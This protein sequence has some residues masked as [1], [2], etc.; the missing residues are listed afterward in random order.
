M[1]QLEVATAPW[2][3]PLTL[4]A[5]A[6]TLV[7]CVGSIESIAE[8]PGTE[9]RSAKAPSSAGV[10]DGTETGDRAEPGKKTVPGVS[11]EPGVAK[12]P[13]LCTTP[14]VST[15][16]MRR[17]THREFGNAVRDLLGTTSAERAFAPDT[18]PELFDTMASQGVSSLLADQYLDVASELAQ[19]ISN[20]STLVGC[21]PG[22]ADATCVRTFT[23]RFARRAYRRPLT[24][25]ERTRLTALYESTRS[26]ANADTAVRAF[27]AA[28]LASP[29]FL[30]RPEWGT[31]QAEFGDLRRAAPFELAARLSFLLWS[32]L[33]D[34]TLLDAAQAGTLSTPAQ[35]TAQAQRM[36]LDPRARSASFGF[37]EQWLGLDLLHS[38][39][40]DKAVYPSFS[41]GLRG[42]MLEET[43]RF[44]DHVIWE[45]DAKLASLLTAPYSFVNKSLAAL[46]KVQGPSDDTT[47]TQ[48]NLDANQRSGVLTQAS[49]L[50]AYAS[51]DT[52]SPV[53]R[54]KWVRTRMF[55]QDLPPPP[56]G[57]PVLAE[58]EEGISTRERF[59][60]HTSAPQCSSCHK[61]IDGLGFG[62]E[63][64][65]G[66]GAFRTIDQGVPVDA[67]GSIV[68]SDVNG[69]YEGGPELAQ[70]L[71]SS[72]QVRDCAVTQWFRFSQGR[73]E[74]DE[75]ACSLQALQASFSGNGGDLQ[76]LLVD[77]IKSDT[78]TFYR[79]PG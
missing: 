23:D 24:T 74:Q 27:V 59:A 46:Y 47:F 9:A 4:G 35:L 33:P 69:A 32:S 78:F 10:G 15:S 55:C 40:K 65:D 37:Y 11:T 61:L 52:S 31:G 5:C 66:I 17:L 50:A 60:M 53:K 6:L 8:L 28:V 36:L 29:H 58:P 19:G 44:V 62:L 14:E 64:Y 42:A 79:S 41:D 20:V 21:T 39:T 54:G 67:S 34:D 26:A 43:R 77:L 51:S 63:S 75:D 45:D 13:L 72:A 1:K 57:I 16:P 73:R 38:S 70:L 18:Q 12:T 7:A 48:V 22:P 30:F 49:M 56:A 2:S 76:T 68:A 25:D 3:R 71:A